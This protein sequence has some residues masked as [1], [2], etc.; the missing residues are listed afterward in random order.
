MSGAAA[1]GIW[2]LL[3]VFVALS[4]RSAQAERFDD[5]KELEVFLDPFVAEKMEQYHIPGAVIVL[6]KN[7]EI[8]FAKG[9]HGNLLGI[10]F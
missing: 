7:G 10:N 4:S 8:F 5:P 2:T 6:V 9:F 3:A 1:R